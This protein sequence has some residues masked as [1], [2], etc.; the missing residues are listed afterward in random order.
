MARWGGAIPFTVSNFHWLRL[1]AELMIDDCVNCFGPHIA[2]TTRELAGH[3]RRRLAFSRGGR[4]NTTDEP[5][6]V[7]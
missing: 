2:A 1:Y 7:I 4:G 5:I 6:E 3:H